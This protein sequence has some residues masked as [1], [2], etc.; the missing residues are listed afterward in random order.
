MTHKTF[1]RIALSLNGAI[2]ASHMGHPD[3]RVANKIFA[4]LHPDL[5][6]GM[7][8]LTPD[9]QKTFIC[10]EST[11]F[12]PE[13]GAWGRSGCT[14]VTLATVD[15]DSLGQALTLAWQNIAANKPSVQPKK[16]GAKTAARSRK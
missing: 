16:K 1:R 15:E 2:E 9:Q 7:V 6:S 10:E 8:K 11:S 14:R 12:A 5:K 13:S 4:S 3:F